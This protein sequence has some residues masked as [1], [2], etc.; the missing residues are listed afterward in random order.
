M[1]SKALLFILA[2]SAPLA[3]AGD[4]RPS[5]YVSLS[6]GSIA[7]EID[8]VDFDQDFFT[9]AGALGFPLHENVAL[10]LRGGRG[11]L[12]SD[13]IFLGVE[14]ST[15]LEH[16]FGAMVK[17][18]IGDELRPYALAGYTKTKLSITATSGPFSATES[19]TD[20]DFSWG[21]GAEYPLN[22]KAGLFAECL[23]LYDQDGE[24]LRGCF[25]G[26]S[27]RF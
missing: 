3:F 22:N 13:D 21:I 4:E 8:D 12:E 15:S 9:M 23:S 19:A 17:L 27:L 25:A 20:G 2:L 1:K 14:T 26:A 11:L 24:T 18:S 16:Y 6:L 5:P 7:Y 10:E